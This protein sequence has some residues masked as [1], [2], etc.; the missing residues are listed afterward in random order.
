MQ[1][2]AVR[3][4]VQRAFLHSLSFK[5]HD[6]SVRNVRL[7]PLYRW[8]NQGT[9]GL[10]HLAGHTEKHRARLGPPCCVVPHIFPT[11]LFIFSAKMTYDPLD[12]QHSWLPPKH[13]QI[14]DGQRARRFIVSSNLSPFQAI[15]R[16][17]MQLWADWITSLR[18]NFF[19]WKIKM[20][21][22]SRY[23]GKR[24]RLKR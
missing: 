2:R 15:P 9:G 14:V 6:N 18:L 24:L 12:S 7:C 5:F 10:R 21:H 19:M 13:H 23:L 17:L 20:V 4:P 11:S 22:S 16:L 1:R 3:T 8:K